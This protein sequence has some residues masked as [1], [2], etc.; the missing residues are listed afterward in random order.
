MG[1]KETQAFC[2]NLG[3]KIGVTTEPGAMD[4]MIL[5]AGRVNEEKCRPKYGTEFGW[6]YSGHDDIQRSGKWLETESRREVELAWYDGYPVDHLFYDCAM[7]NYD[8]REYQDHTCAWELCPICKFEE[9]FLKFHL[10][11][12]CKDSIVDRYYVA[13]ERFNLM[14]YMRT[15]ISWQNMRWEIVDEDTNTQL[16]FWNETSTFPL[17]LHHWYFSEQSCTDPGQAYRSLR[18]HLDVEQPGQFC[19][20][21][22]A[23]LPS[24]QVCDDLYECED[25]SDEKNCTIMT[26][27]DNRFNKN[28]PPVYF[29][30]EGKKAPLPVSASVEIYKVFDVNEKD[31]SFDIFFKLTLLWNDKN[32]RQ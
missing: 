13:T 6:F 25:R 14:G 1:Y 24:H 10:A 32:I 3:G 9:T 4:K 29:N 7:F 11:G 20:D 18:L 23:C 2:S 5:A 31:S 28:K 16:A 27:Q 30:D 26:L 12:V 8:T 17:G 15:R 22:G 21:D 19:C